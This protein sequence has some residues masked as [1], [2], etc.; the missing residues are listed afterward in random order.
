M[1]FER[2]LFKSLNTRWPFQSSKVGLDELESLAFRIRYSSR[3]GATLWSCS[4]SSMHA[5]IQAVGGVDSDN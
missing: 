5:A 1:P 3:I 2:R 4:R